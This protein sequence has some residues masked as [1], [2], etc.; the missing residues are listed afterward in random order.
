MNFNRA[1]VPVIGVILLACMSVVQADSVKT[2]EWDDLIPPQAMAELNKGDIADTNYNGEPVVQ[3]MSPL[4]S[5]VRK[6]LDGQQVKLPGFIVPLEGA[7]GK[8]TE[9]LL[10]PYFGACMHTPPPP[11]NQIVYVNYPKG[12]STE[13]LY[14]PV[15]IEGPIKV[16]ELESALAVSGYSMSAASVFLY[17]ETE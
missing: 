12:V 2:L 8:V 13:M 3:T 16:G 6:E 10:V 7:E 4:I 5:A 17:T 14:D 11:V 1:L 15:W 9:F